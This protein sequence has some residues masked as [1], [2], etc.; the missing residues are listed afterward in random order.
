MPNILSLPE[1]NKPKHNYTGIQIVNQME[2]PTRK[3][4]KKLQRIIHPLSVEAKSYVKDSYHVK[5]IVRGQ[6]SITLYSTV[7]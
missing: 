1:S 2:D 4:Y 3:N 7:L 6:N 5:Q